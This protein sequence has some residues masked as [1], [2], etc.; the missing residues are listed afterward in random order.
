MTKEEFIQRYRA[1]QKHGTG[2]GILWLVLFFGFLTGSAI[3]SKPHA[4]RE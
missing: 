2:W 4:Q 3:F 1:Q